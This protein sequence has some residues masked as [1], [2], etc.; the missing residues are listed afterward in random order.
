MLQTRN[1]DTR[2][3]NRVLGLSGQ[4]HQNQRTGPVLMSEPNPERESVFRPQPDAVNVCKSLIHFFFLLNF[5]EEPFDPFV[6]NRFRKMKRVRTCSF[7]THSEKT[8]R[9]SPTCQTVHQDPG[10]YSSSSGPGSKTKQRLSET[11]WNITG[12][13]FHELQ[14]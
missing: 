7:L 8:F 4:N 5:S 12:Q 1:Q 9:T 3:R 6:M 2:T 13:K 14:R 11:D 10:F